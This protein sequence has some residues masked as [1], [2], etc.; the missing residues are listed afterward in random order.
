MI[1]II[2][3]IYTKLFSLLIIMSITKNI[4]FI[5]AG[6]STNDI[7]NSIN[8]I[9]L[10]K[11]KTSKKSILN[12]FSNSNED[13]IKN[14]IIKKN[15]LSRLDKIG[16]KEL[17]MCQENE[18]NSLIFK[19]TKKVYTSLDYQ[20]I[21][22][23]FILFRN[24][25]VND[26]IIYPLPY[27]SNETNIKSET[28]LDK[29]KKKFSK[30]TTNVTTIVN[31]YWDTKWNILDLKNSFYNIKKF[32]TKINWKYAEMKVHSYFTKKN[33]IDI[34][35]LHNYSFT[36]F[37]LLFEKICIED[38]DN[39]IIFICK[40]NVITDFL[41]TFKKIKF[42]IKKDNL[43]Y[44]S[45]WKMNISVNN[46]KKTVQ[47]IDYEKI[48]PT[49]YNYKPLKY[50]IDTDNETFQ[51]ILNGQKYILFNSLKCIPINYL[52]KINFQY[53]YYTKNKQNSIIKV[54][55]KNINKNSKNE[56]TNKTD[57]TYESLT[58]FFGSNK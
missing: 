29:F 34:H 21:E 57:D 22:S 35:S 49:E 56:K 37:K 44:T 45:I 13:D 39:N 40:N 3:I 7:I 12:F 53:Q 25:T 1:Y 27:M 24:K 18:E 46:L 52:K 38:N 11:H 32:S 14:E 41:K 33:A 8:D 17:Y 5:C 4:Y 20:S 50:N 42:D 58:G 48:Y 28:T 47:Y 16:I 43:E 9:I 26:F 23:S 15:D 30:S 2:F 19:K 51:Y 31:K 6:V 36:K 55:N 54:L 10:K